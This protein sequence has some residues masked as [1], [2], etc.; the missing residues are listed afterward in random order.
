MVR[1]RFV[2]KTLDAT[3]LAAL[4][5]LLLLEITLK[6]ICLRDWLKREKFNGLGRV[7]WL[8]I[9]LFVTLFGPI[10]YLVYGRREYDRY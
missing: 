7:P 4:I 5:P 6:L 9:F 3:I 1:R 10:A 8:L 2:M